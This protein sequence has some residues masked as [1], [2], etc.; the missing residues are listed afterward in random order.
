MRKIDSMG[1]ACDPGPII[2]RQPDD[3]FATEAN[4]ADNPPVVRTEISD[5]PFDARA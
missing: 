1:V 3:T 4:S 2:L 5:A